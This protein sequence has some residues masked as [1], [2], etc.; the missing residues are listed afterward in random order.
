VSVLLS[1][2]V[3]L[4]RP[5][6]LPGCGHAVVTVLSSLLT[7]CRLRWV[8]WVR[9]RGAVKWE[10]SACAV[11]LRRSSRSARRRPHGQR[12]IS[13]PAHMTSAHSM[14]PICP[15]SPRP[16]VVAAPH[17]RLLR[18]TTL[19]PR[20]RRSTRRTCPSIPARRLISLRHATAIVCVVR[21]HL[22]RINMGIAFTWA[23]A[24]CVAEIV[25]ES[26]SAA[27]GSGAYRFENMGIASLWR[28]SALVPHTTPLPKSHRSHVMRAPEGAS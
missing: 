16:Y 20:P 1:R 18:R 27:T 11:D 12:N 19:Y 23:P 5:F 24:K 13:S 17:K 21:L 25:F 22:Y 9:R 26:Y 10:R 3:A 2:S 8:N 15:P 14:P 4:S 28:L 7:L 6:S